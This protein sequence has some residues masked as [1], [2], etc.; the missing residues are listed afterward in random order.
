MGMRVAAVEAVE[1]AE[2][3]EDAEDAEDAEVAAAGERCTLFKTRKAHLTPNPLKAP[4][5][6]LYLM[7]TSYAG[8]AT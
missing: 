7:Q 6:N 3:A 5:L 2:A 1:A 4:R 8:H